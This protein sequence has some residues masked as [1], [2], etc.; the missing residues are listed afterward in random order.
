MK[1]NERK[2]VVAGGGLIGHCAPPQPWREI[3]ASER[4][5]AVPAQSEVNS[6]TVTRQKEYSR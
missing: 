5:Y 3:D 6:Q 4:R 2:T 1:V